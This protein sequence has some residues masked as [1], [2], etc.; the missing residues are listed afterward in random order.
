MGGEDEKSSAN[1]ILAWNS[2][3]S[4]FLVDVVHRARDRNWKA[5]Y[6]R[7]CLPISISGPVSSFLADPGAEWLQKTPGINVFNDGEDFA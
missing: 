2:F 1:T 4:A 6:E 3:H 7:C 5:N